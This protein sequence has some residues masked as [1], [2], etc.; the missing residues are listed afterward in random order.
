MQCWQT[1]LPKGYIMVTKTCRV[2]FCFSAIKQIEQMLHNSY[3]YVL[4][5]SKKHFPQLKKV[6]F[7][8]IYLSTADHVCTTQDGQKVQHPNPVHTRFGLKFVR[9]FLLD[10]TS[11]QMVYG[12]E[13][14][15]RIIFM[16]QLH[17]R[18]G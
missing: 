9:N 4:E 6:F 17:E 18:F 7:Y 14:I 10:K 12:Q 1:R 5:V 15:S 8:K 16:P 2:Y 3:L 11:H 13:L